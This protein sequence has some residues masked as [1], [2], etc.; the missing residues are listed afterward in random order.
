[1]IGIRAFNTKIDLYS[2]KGTEGDE[3][4]EFLSCF[5]FLLLG[6]IFIGKLEVIGL[7][8]FQ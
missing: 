8:D 5:L 2:K 3:N 7:R 6:L 1:M 4:L